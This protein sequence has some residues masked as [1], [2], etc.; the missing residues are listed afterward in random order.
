MTSRWETIINKRAGLAK[1]CLATENFTAFHVLTAKQARSPIPLEDLPA[2]VVSDIDK[3]NTDTV[4][5]SEKDYKDFSDEVEALKN[6]QPDQAGWEA[7]INAA[8]EKAKIRAVDAIEKG[9]VDAI[10]YIGAL[11]E[12]IR[13]SASNLWGE[14]L[15]I[16]LAFVEKVYESLKVII[17]S[18]V[19]FLQGIWD[20]ITSTWDAIVTSASAAIDL[21]KGL[22]SFTA[23]AA[24]PTFLPASASLYQVQKQVGSYIK[25][26]SS[27]AKPTSSM[28][29][30]KQGRGWEIVVI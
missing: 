24:K 28:T 26:L 25:Q 30:N 12:P 20:K 22:F 21:I 13:D 18:I 16:V 1:L 23:Q 11:P 5:T 29:I 9:R 3:I 4:D 14:G 8:A 10:S 2:D 27:S 17:D 19:E 6:E 15:D 7:T